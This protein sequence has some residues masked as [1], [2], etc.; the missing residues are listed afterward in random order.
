MISELK[1]PAESIEIRLPIKLNDFREYGESVITALT[2]YAI[3]RKG[4][5]I[6]K[7]NYEGV[8]VN[9]E[10]GWFLLRLSV[11]D[12]ILPL[13]IENDKMGVCS[14]IAKELKEFF[15]QFD[16]LDLSGLIR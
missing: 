13:N 10:G 16:K 1:E 6:E 14:E 2:D 15:A 7:E 12:P 11:H 5:E 3:S 9:I 4:F 8:R